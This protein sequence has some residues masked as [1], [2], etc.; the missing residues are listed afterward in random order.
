[1]KIEIILGNWDVIKAIVYSHARNKPIW[2]MCIIPSVL[3]NGVSVVGLWAMDWPLDGIISVTGDFLLWIFGLYF[4]G[5]AL[6][7]LSLV[8]NPKW[9][10]GRIG[11]HTIEIDERGIIESTEYNRSE[12]YWPS[13]RNVSSKPSGIFFLHSGSDS[14]LIPRHAFDSSESWQKF[15][16]KF[17]ALYRGNN[18]A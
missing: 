6:T 18:N 1:M 3:I 11:R 15:E 16:N 5:L 13:V 7:L 14:F 4:V 10:K 9:R 12:I 8:G 2:A 17:Y